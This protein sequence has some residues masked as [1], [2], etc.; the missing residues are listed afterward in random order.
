MSNTIGFGQAAINNTIDYG[1]GATDNTIN[2]G[3]SQT[4]SPSGETNITGT[5]STPSFT[6]VNSFSFDGIDDTF[7]IPTLPSTFTNLSISFWLKKGVDSSNAYV[8]SRST[9]Q[10][11]IFQ[12][13][14]NNSLKYRLI[15]SGGTYTKTGGAILDSQ[16]H[17]CAFVWDSSANTFDIYEDGVKI[18]TS[19]NT[20]GSLISST[21]SAYIFSFVNGAPYSSGK[22]DELAIFDSA[23]S[24]SDVSAIYNN[25]EPQ[26][27]DAYSPLIWF[28]MGDNAT[29]N[30]A[31]WTMTSVGTDTR[32]A[33]SINMVE[34]NRTTDVPTASSFTNVNSFS[35][36]GIDEIFQ[37]SSI[38]SELNGGTK[39]TVSV[40]VKPIS[41]APILEYIISNPRN[42]TSNQHQFALTLLGSVGLGR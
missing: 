5:P 10:W 17:H 24:Q 6:N 40:W 16:W 35:F 33:R 7:L 36:D 22:V 12:N 37:G 39:L 23:L 28:R 38:Y 30:G 20:S 42:S 3:K 31:T 15:T 21:A 9:S 4:L 29:W 34:A 27:L 13:A 26:S 41:G 2:W 14:T 18:G 19:T 1:Q 11:L 8:F 32:I 25:G